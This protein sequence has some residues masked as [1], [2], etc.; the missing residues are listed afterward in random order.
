MA[1][2]AYM[3][4]TMSIESVIAPL[5]IETLQAAKRVALRYV[6]EGSDVLDMLGLSDA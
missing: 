3:V 1:A 2:N 6:G 5:P 4:D